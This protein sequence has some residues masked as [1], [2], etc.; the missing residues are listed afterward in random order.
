MYFPSM[1]IINSIY[2]KNYRINY[3]PLMRSDTGAETY[4]PDS[5][6]LQNEGTVRYNEREDKAIYVHRRTWVV[7][8]LFKQD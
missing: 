2:Q 6:S 8:F 4:I 3:V 1:Q 5:Y 7:D